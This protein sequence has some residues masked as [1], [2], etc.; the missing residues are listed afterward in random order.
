MYI[1]GRSWSLY[2]RVGGILLFI[3]GSDIS[4]NWHPKTSLRLRV[5]LGQS[6]QNNYLHTTPTYTDLFI[7]LSFEASINIVLVADMTLTVECNVKNC[8]HSH[9]SCD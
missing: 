1:A 2:K 4:V 8:S 5:R 6:K 9:S 3:C 7:D